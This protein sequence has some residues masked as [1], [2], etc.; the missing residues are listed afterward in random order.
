MSRSL[1]LRNSF[2]STSLIVAVIT[3]LTGVFGLFWLLGMTG[4]E[5]IAYGAAFLLLI[6]ILILFVIGSAAGGWVWIFLGK[7]LFGL[8]HER[9]YSLFFRNQPYIPLITPYNEWCMKMVFP[10]EER[11]RKRMEGL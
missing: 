11:E 8:T 9:A 6:Y 1:K 7:H 10:V 2:L 4:E 5:E 3:M